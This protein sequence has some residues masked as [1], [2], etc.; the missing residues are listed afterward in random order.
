ML[1]AS[2]WILHPWGRCSGF[3]FDFKHPVPVTIL[4]RP[5]SEIV[6]IWGVWLLFSKEAGDEPLDLFPIHP[7][8]QLKIGESGCFRL[9]LCASAEKQHGKQAQDPIRHYSLTLTSRIS[10]GV[11]AV[12]CM[13]WFDNPYSSPHTTA[14]LAATPTKYLPLKPTFR[15]MPTRL[16]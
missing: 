2:I 8:L 14:G 12:G 5:A 10:C 7:N 3:V 9:R 15:M 6:P 4:N 1:H 13:R 16:L 11:L